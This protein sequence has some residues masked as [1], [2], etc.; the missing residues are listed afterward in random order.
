MPGARFEE[1]FVS[2]MRRMAREPVDIPAVLRGVA[3]GRVARQVAAAYDR[4]LFDG[5]LLQSLP[6]NPRFIFTSANLQS[7]ALWR[8]SKPYMGD[9]KVGRRTALICRTD[10]DIGRCRGPA[11]SGEL[12]A[13]SPITRPRLVCRAHPISQSPLA[14]FPL[15]CGACQ[16]RIRSASSIG[17]MQFVTTPF[18]HTSIQ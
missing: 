13:R 7:D 10:R 8:F 3:L 5:A 1:V 2:G 12:T 4:V 6:D 16:R 18:A 17:A 15:V 14:K 11:R 9:Y